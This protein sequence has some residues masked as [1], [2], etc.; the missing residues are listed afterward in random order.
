MAKEYIPNAIQDILDN[1][2]KEIICGAD[3][4]KTAESCVD[5]EVAYKLKLVEHSVRYDASEE[6]EMQ[7]CL[8]PPE[9]I[10]GKLR[11]DGRCEIRRRA[12]SGPDFKII[13]E[14]QA[15]IMRARYLLLR[16]FYYRRMKQLPYSIQSEVSE[17]FDI[18]FVMDLGNDG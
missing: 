8:S 11:P 9:V 6:Q 2:T 14:Q 13:S 15:E 17:K 12:E 1:Y 5:L 16:G 10:I 18:H 7:L 4:K 3:V